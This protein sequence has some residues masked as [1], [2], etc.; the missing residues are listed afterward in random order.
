MSLLTRIDIILQ[1]NNIFV[2][3]PI[4]CQDYV[5]KFVDGNLIFVLIGDYYLGPYSILV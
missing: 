4:I 3:P 1:Y 5:S 2:D